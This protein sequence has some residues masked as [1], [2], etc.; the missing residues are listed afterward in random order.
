MFCNRSPV[1]S[2]RPWR[3]RLRTRSGASGTLECHDHVWVL[4]STVFTYSLT[5]LLC[6]RLLLYH[7]S[8]SDEI[9]G[10]SQYRRCGYAHGRSCRSWGHFV[11]LS[12]NLGVSQPIIAYSSCSK[13]RITLYLLT[14]QSI[15]WLLALDL[16]ACHRVSNFLPT[17]KV[18]PSSGL[19]W[20]LLPLEYSPVSEHWASWLYLHGLDLEVSSLQSS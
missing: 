20:Q 13:F 10:S 4:L 9:Q 12:T 7:V 17:A 19:W 8:V 1:N 18:V 3:G 15:A 11:S 6:P 2:L 14:W 5:K 16:L